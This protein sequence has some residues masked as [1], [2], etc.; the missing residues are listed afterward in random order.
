MEHHHQEN[1]A[2]AEGNRHHEYRIQISYERKCGHCF[3]GTQPERFYHVFKAKHT[4]ETETENGGKDT[5]AAYDGRKV[6]F[7]KLIQKHAAHKQAQPLPHIPEHSSENN[8]IGYGYKNRGIK[9]LIVGKPIHPDK[10]FKGFENLRVFQLGRRLAEPVLQAFALT[11]LDHTEN[12]RIPFDF[13]LEFL[14]ILL[15]H[16]SAEDKENRILRLGKC[17]QTA[18]IEIFGALRNRLCSR[19]YFGFLRL[20]LILEGILQFP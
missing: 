14:R 7:F 2:H 19:Q 16:P 5:A 6:E 13:F 9:F 18:Y 11:V 15:R 20:Q 12:I 1:Q 17:R 3:G 4:A 10:H 8:G